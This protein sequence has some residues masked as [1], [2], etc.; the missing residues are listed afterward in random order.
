MNGHSSCPEA[1]CFWRPYLRLLYGMI[2]LSNLAPSTE[3]VGTLTFPLQVY[4]LNID[5]YRLLLVLDLY[6][7]LLD[8]E[9]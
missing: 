6:H 8:L 4:E 2:E 9:V 7:L 3:R 5:V 1:T